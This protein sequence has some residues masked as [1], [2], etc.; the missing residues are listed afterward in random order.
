MRMK[1][2]RG[3]PELDIISV[4]Q[5]SPIHPRFAS[6]PMDIDANIIE[7]KKESVEL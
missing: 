1:I 5:T 3:F 6:S 7:F 2:L 4:T